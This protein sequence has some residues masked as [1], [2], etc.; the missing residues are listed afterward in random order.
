MQRLKMGVSWAHGYL[1]S[2]FMI[3]YELINF[4]FIRSLSN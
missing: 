2:H 3:I 1:K 4:I